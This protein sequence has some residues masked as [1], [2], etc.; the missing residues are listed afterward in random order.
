[1]YTDLTNLLPP[2]RKQLLARDY[3]LRVGVVSAVLITILTLAAAVLLIPTYV[4]LGASANEKKIHLTNMES[5]LS[6]NEEATLSAR[7]AILSSNAA[8]LASLSDTVS[9]SSIMR[10]VLAVSRAGITL[11]GFSYTPAVEKVAGTLLISGTSATRDALRN[12]QLALQGM[13]FV[14]SATL[15]VSAYANDTNISFT[16]TIVLTP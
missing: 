6:S 8:K 15:P 9:V 2:E 12:Y 1:M 4:L 7:L 5:S 11:S 13:P 10:A 3:L 16:I 14:R